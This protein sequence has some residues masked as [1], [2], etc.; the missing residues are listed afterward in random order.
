[1]T[2]INREI[3]Q[4]FLSLTNMPMEL[5]FVPFWSLANMPLKLLFPFVITRTMR[6]YIYVYSLLFPCSCN[7]Q[8]RELTYWVQKLIYNHNKAL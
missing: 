5:L 2:R 6:L 3:V 1:M 8:P 4:I 7:F